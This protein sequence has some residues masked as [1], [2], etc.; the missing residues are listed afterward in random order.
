MKRRDFLK[1]M[2][3]AAVAPML[4]DGGHDDELRCEML[5]AYL[6]SPHVAPV[7]WKTI[8]EVDAEFSGLLPPPRFVVTLR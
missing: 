7:V 6:N 3:A 5:A 1:L 4:P 2:P 8:A